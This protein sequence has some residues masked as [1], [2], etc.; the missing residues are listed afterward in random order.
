MNR[1]ILATMICVVVAL[2]GCGRSARKDKP[3]EPPEVIAT[4]QTG[5]AGERSGAA[6]GAEEGSPLAV[7]VADLVASAKYVGKIVTVEGR[8]A[9]WSSDLAAGGPPV[10]R[11]DWVLEDGGQ[12]IYVTGPLPAGCSSTEGG[13]ERVTIVARVAE[14][15]LPVM[16]EGSEAKA[17]RYLVAIP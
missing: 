17:R 6:V 3:G 8:C 15:S 5:T 11:S 9:G 7:T 10:T 14:D 1:K 12:G 13:S 4:T 2:A 16:G